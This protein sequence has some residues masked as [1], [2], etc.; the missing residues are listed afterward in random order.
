MKKQTMPAKR[1]VKR[2]CTYLI[3][4][5]SA[6]IV[7][8]SCKKEKDEVKSYVEIDGDRKI[9]STSDLCYTGIGANISITY[10]N[11]SLY[12]LTDGV[13]ITSWN[14][15]DPV[16]SGN[17]LFVQFNLSTLNDEKPATGEYPW[18]LSSE[19][20]Q[21]VGG[22]YANITAGVRGEVKE[23]STGIT[24][25]KYDGEKMSITYNGTDEYNTAIS[26]FFSGIPAFHDLYDPSRK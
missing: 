11:Y 10:Y 23:F 21:L 24:E 1:S 19:G 14:S 16:F 3:L 5:L 15:S 26:V 7:F 17:G 4:A 6:G 12:L 9:I 18:T 8:T 25:V 13:T 22:G 2:I 20:N